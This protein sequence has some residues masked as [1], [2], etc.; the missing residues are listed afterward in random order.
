MQTLHTD[1]I[2]NASAE[3]V[4]SILMDFEKYPEWNPF[5]LSIAGKQ[6]V[7]EELRVVLKNGDGT[8]VFKPKVVTLEKN[9]AF[10]WLGKLPLGIFTGQHQFRIVKIVDGQVRF[11]HSEQFSGLLAGMIMKKIGEQTKKGFE[12]MNE[13]L[14]KRA[15]G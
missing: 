5:I 3:K 13:A 9:T 7:G 1:I 2:I 4:W 11:M 10:E 12:G 15:E 14:K 8:S 6:Q